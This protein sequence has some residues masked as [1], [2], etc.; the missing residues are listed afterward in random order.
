MKPTWVLL[1]EP[2]EWR[3]MDGRAD[4]DWYPT[5]ILLRQREHGQWETVLPDIRRIVTEAV[6]RKQRGETLHHGRIGR[7]RCESR[8]AIEFQPALAPRGLTS[9]VE[10]SEGIFQVQADDATESISLAWYG[11]WRHDQLALLAKLVRLGQTVIETDSGAGVHAVAMSRLVGPT[12]HIL[13]FDQQA[14]RRRILA[15]NLRANRADNVTIFPSTCG[16]S[17]TS[18]DRSTESIDGLLLD[19]LDWIKINN[20]RHF[21]DVVAGAERS[22]W[23]LRPRFF[24]DAGSSTNDIVTHLRQLSYSCWLHSSEVFR[25][26]NFNRLTE[27]RGVYATQLAVLAIPEEVLVDVDLA[28]CERLD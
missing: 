11:E 3:W 25:N 18:A 8:Q 21:D 20:H 16:R 12:G 13:L 15:Q 26:S 6:D 22:I 10:A 28:P 24:V 19:R 4:S 23:T 1:P 14:Q 2:A 5:A 9:L 27:S 17:E 7:E